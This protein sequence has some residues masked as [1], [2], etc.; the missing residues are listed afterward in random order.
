MKLV[1][2]VTGLVVTVAH[3]NQG[4][5]VVVGGPSGSTEYQVDDSIPVEVGYSCTVTAGVPV[6]APVAPLYTPNIV[7]IGVFLSSIT[8]LELAGLRA[9][10]DPL[11]QQFVLLCDDPRITAIDLNLPRIQFDINYAAG[12][13]AAPAG[14]ANA[15]AKMTSPPIGGAARAAAI[16]AGNP[17]AANS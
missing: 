8:A 6:F 2:V 4:A 1:Y 10:S 13:V 15:G 11:V 9:S 16:L 3:I 5:P 17:L 12:L 14:A 7:S